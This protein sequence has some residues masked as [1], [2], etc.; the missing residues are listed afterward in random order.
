LIKSG[1]KV[2]PPYA[3]Q[4]TKLHS[5]SNEARKKIENSESCAGEET[6]IS[7]GRTNSLS[8]QEKQTVSMS[9]QK[10]NYSF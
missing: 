1:A 9:E 3:D 5:E 10:P 2:R 6:L 8:N 4:R 7:G